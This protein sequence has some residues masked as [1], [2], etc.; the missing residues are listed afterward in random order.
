MGSAVTPSGAEVG[1]E[2]VGRTGVSSGSASC[3]QAARINPAVAAA[4]RLTNCRL[5]KG[6]YGKSNRFL[7]SILLFVMG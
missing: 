3:P 2:F 7:E 1:A 6:G 4:P 5:V